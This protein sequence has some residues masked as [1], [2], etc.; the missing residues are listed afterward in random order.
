MSTVAFTLMESGVDWPESLRRDFVLSPRIL[1]QAQSFVP[2][3]RLSDDDRVAL[4]RALMK[5]RILC[6]G[7]RG[8]VR[9]GDG[10]VLS[11]SDAVGFISDGSDRLREAGFPVFLPRDWRVSDMRVVPSVRPFAGTADV[12]NAVSFDMHLAVGPS[13]F[14][15]QQLRDMVEEHSRAVQLKNQWV[16]ANAQVVNDVIEYLNRHPGGVVEPT[17]VIRDMAS[18]VPPVPFS[19]VQAQDWVEGLFNASIPS[20]V[21]P[22]V[23]LRA[24]LRDYQVRGVT[25]MSYM[26]DID[27]GC[28][29]ADDMGLGKTMQVLALEC[30]VRD[31]FPKAP[32]SIIACPMSVVGSWAREAEKFA[33]HLRVYV[34][35]GPNRAHGDELIERIGDSDLVVTTYAG[36]VSSVE[37][38][39]EFEFERVILDEAQ[40]I[41]TARTAQSKAVRRLKARHRLAMTGTP[42]ENRLS[43]L[44]S[45]LEFCNPGVLGT[46]NAFQKNFADP[47]EREGDTEVLESL[48]RITEPFL[49]RR[50]KSDPAV[51]GDL[52]EKIEKVLPVDITAE[53]ATL[54]QA[55]LDDAT[56][57]IKESSGPKRKQS[58][59]AALGSLKQVCND[60]GQYLGDDIGF[61]KEGEYRSGKVEAAEEIVADVLERGEKVL[62]FTQYR[63]FGEELSR[64]F[65][66]RFDLEEVPFLHG[67]VTR[68]KRDKMVTGFQSPE[69]P[70]VM[71]L[72]LH[73]AGTGITLTAANHVIH[74]DRWWNPAVED[75]ATDRAYRIGQDRDVMVWKMM[76]T[77]TLEERIDQ[78]LSS[79]RGLADSVVKSGEAWITELSDDDLQELLALSV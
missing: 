52:P 18:D 41:K 4:S 34:H 3:S 23:S 32:A 46:A 15:L 40:H 59:L 69:G 42:V 22:P 62:V 60:P 71:I 66:E 6:P 31:R 19:D 20:P 65:R 35:H 29:L 50:L 44:H 17:G 36:I 14:S 58:I 73:A 26:S 49:L 64:L 45:I 13:Q 8:L 21:T 33:P 9:H 48:R 74:M 38:L 5:V 27:V 16:D 47:V 37:T 79:K 10:L 43:E 75:Q 24:T 67:G 30:Y 78:M 12:D 77:G 2:E 55:I 72:S 57:G 70:P 68:S 61:M 7:L 39:E 51:A 76:C 1:S 11:Q 56:S 28:I 53:Q 63:K 54:Y 25:W